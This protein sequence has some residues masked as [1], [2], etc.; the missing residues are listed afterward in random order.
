MASA[1]M[2]VRDVCDR[3]K[4][5]RSTVYREANAGRLNLVKLGRMTRIRAAD[6]EAWALASFVSAQSGGQAQ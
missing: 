1:M 6:A 3:F 5:S 4:V 2:T